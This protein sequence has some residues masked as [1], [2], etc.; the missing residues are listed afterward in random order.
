[1]AVLEKE[2]G[3]NRANVVLGRETL[4]V[5]YVYL[6]NFE[7]ARFFPRYLVQQRRDHFARAAP[8]RP[9]IDDHRFIVLRQFAVKVRFVKRDN[10]R[11]FHS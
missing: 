2:Q 4:V 11:I 3:R 5:V 7:C 1:L 9:K 8:L 6:R 10:S